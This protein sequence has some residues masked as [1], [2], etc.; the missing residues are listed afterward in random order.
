MVFF[1]LW[2]QLLGFV[3]ADTLPRHEFMGVGGA[4]GVCV[5]CVCVCRGGGGLPAFVHYIVPCAAPWPHPSHCLPSTIA[6][7]LGPNLPQ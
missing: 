6:E 1:T 5:V 3:A 2:L 4:C 7:L